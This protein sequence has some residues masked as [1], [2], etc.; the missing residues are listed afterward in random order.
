MRPVTVQFFKNPDI[1]HWGFEAWVLGD[2]E[3]GSWIAAPKGTKRWKGEQPVRPS[4]EHAV[5]C[6]PK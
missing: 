4:R 5:F 1:L 6:A 2:D 3:Y